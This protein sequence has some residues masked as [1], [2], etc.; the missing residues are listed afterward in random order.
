AR[1]LAFTRPV[2]FENEIRALGKDGKYRWFLFRYK[3]LLDE[4]GKIDRWY[5]A[6]FDIDDRR[7]AEEALQSSERNLR[8]MI[9]AIPAMVGVVRADGSLLY[10]NQATLDYTGVTL[11][12]IPKQDYRV[13]VYHPEDLERQREERQLAFTHPV[14]F[15]TEQRVL[16]KD[17]QYRWHL[18]RF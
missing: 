9:N 13:R 6:A 3:P 15:N 17:G 16:G 2:P 1:R 14:P 18:T 4:A 12:D 11:E 8:L 10:A 7:K 5:M